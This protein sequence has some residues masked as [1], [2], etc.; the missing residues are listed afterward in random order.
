MARLNGTS[1][2]APSLVESRAVLLLFFLSIVCTF[3]SG[4]TAGMGESCG[5][6]FWMMDIAAVIAATCSL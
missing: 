1:F 2:P 4:M 5:C 3:V 6:A